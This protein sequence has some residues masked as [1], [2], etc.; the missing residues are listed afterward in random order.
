VDD[1][2]EARRALALASGKIQA[3]EQGG[4]G[5]SGE[6]DVAEGEGAG[7]GGRGVRARANVQTISSMRRAPVAGRAAEAPSGAGEEQL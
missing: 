6:G 3:L 7:R 4:G 2:Q 1:V 5:S